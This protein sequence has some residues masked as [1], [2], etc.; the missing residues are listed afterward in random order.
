MRPLPDV[1]ELVPHAPPMLALDRLLEA[2]DGH[3]VAE[4][5]LREDNL[6]VEAGRVD[7][8]L[9]L[10]YMAQ[11]VA[12]CLGMQAFRAG[13]GVRIGMVVG[14][15]RFVLQRS[16][17]AVGERLRIEVRRRS[18]TADASSFDAEVRDAAGAAVA[19]AM[20][21]LVHGAAPPA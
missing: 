9:L 7:G 2:G 19:T 6:F 21:L 3:A 11:T 8:V 4:L 5:T 15:R 20:L 18:G 12:A 10:E 16:S 17:L 1:A 14:C 13:E